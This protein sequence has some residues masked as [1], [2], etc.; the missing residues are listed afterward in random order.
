MILATVQDAVRDELE[1]LLEV[2]PGRV[3]YA[4][5]RRED[6]S[7]L[8]E[9][10]LDL[11]REPEARFV[12]GDAPLSSEEVSTDD[13]QSV[14]E[15]L[16]EFGDD[17]RAGIERT[18]HRISAIRNRRG[19]VVG[20][21]CRIGRAVFGTIK[22]IEDLALSGKN[23]LLLGR[24]GVGKTTMLREMAR[25]LSVSANKRVV[26]VDTSNEIAGDGDVPHP[27]IGR[28]RRMQ[29][30][31]PLQQHG[32]MIEAVENHMP[33]AVVID[34]MG[35]EQEAAA[36]R[37]I[38]ERGVQLI[39]T[40]HGNTLD[41][42][43]MNPTLSDLVGGIQTVTLGD[44]EARYRGTQKTVLERKAPPTFDVVVEIQSWER[45]A[46]HSDVAHV[47][48][49]WLRGYP[50]V[51]EIRWIDENG[52]LQ[53]A[54]EEY[55]TNEDAPAP[56]K[57]EGRRN[58]REPGT[59][60]RSRDHNRDFNRDY[61]REETRSAA[62]PRLPSPM[63]EM[64]AEEAAMVSEVHVFLFGVGRDKLEAAMVES[65]VPAQIVNELRRADVVLTTKTHYRR[66]SQLVRIA[67][68][69]GKPVFVLRKNSLPQLQDFLRTVVGQW[70]RNGGRTATEAEDRPPGP[71]HRAGHGG[72]GRGG[73]SR[74]RR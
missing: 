55:R 2:L 30:A 56:W 12:S 71:Q 19:R 72:G 21:T 47:V 51:P 57:P 49:Q 44:Q 62:T 41:N 65:G 26:I 39:A 50:I 18:L 16:G 31:T 42:L 4:L 36:A 10:V 46:V 64:S 7:E 73:Q 54:E 68:A 45:L 37:T 69:N 8:L 58:G 5:R 22:M 74:I 43:I 53:R 14:I 34:E 52:E 33:E 11:G 27:A 15:R 63:G 40:A 66:G 17:N 1:L 60:R 25:V 32:V 6:L 35:A 3:S 23:I 67:E 70:N 20:L 9:V 29:V 24:P 13:L 61:N 59:E 38:A 48:D 28:A